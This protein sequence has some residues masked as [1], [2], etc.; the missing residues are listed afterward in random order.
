[1]QLLRARPN[2]SAIGYNTVAIIFFCSRSLQHESYLFIRAKLERKIITSI[3]SN[4]YLTIPFLVPLFYIC[5]SVAL[6]FRPTKYELGEASQ[7]ATVD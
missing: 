4:F 2:E 7:Q 5:L 1:V 3:P 6:M